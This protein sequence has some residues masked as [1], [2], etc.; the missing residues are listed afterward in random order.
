MSSEPGVT[1]VRRPR[2]R[3]QR[4]ID[5]SAGLKASIVAAATEIFSERG[6]TQTTLDA[7]ARQVGLTRPGVLHHFSSKEV[8]F[9]AVLSAQHDW[10][11]ARIS[12]QHPPRG[13]SGIAE[14]RRLVG[15][16]EESRTQLRLIHVLEGEGIAGNAA[17]I[18]YVQQRTHYVREFIHERLVEA[19]TLGEIA[20][21]H[22]L[23]SLTTLVAAAVNGLQQ[24]WLIDARRETGAPFDTLLAMLTVSDASPK[25][26]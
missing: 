24:A 1:S 17:A 9:A 5:D 11:D 22:D 18:E 15:T 6:Y 19:R 16:A 14:L 7:V 25:I 20:S 10:A 8:L 26:D 2:N 12:E 4:Q 23:D 13:L 3:S 21:D